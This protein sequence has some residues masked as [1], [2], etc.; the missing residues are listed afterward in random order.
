M[1]RLEFP[2]GSVAGPDSRGVAGAGLL[3]PRAPLARRS[4][5]VPADTHRGALQLSE[6][7][8]QQ[9]T[10]APAGASRSSDVAGDISPTRP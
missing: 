7:E 8:L 3:Q 1:F 5:G 2:I 10:C 6:P 4:P 9:S